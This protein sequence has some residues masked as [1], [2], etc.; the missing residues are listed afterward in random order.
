MSITKWVV[1]MDPAGMSQR[2]VICPEVPREM[3]ALPARMTPESKLIAL[4]TGGSVPA[5]KRRMSPP[6]PGETT[7]TI[8]AT[9]LAVDGTSQRPATGNVLAELA[10]SAGPPE[11]PGE[12]RVSAT[13]Q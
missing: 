3:T 9:D 12:L 4:V 10:E 2:A 6:A 8:T 13:R 1:A 11:G 7:A 5:G